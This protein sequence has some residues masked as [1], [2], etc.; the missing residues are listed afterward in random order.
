MLKKQDLTQRIAF[1]VTDEQY[2][3]AQE[4]A[5]LEG[6]PTVSSF[7]R[8]LLDRALAAQKAFKEGV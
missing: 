7:L 4:L 3:G 1:L 5:E 2:E 6:Q 8:L